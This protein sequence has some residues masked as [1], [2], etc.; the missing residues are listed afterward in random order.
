MIEGCVTENAPHWNEEIKLIIFHPF[1]RLIACRLF[2]PV[3]HVNLIP[4][5]GGGEIHHHKSYIVMCG[6]KGYGFSTVLV[7]V[8]K[9]SISADLGIL[10][11]NRVWFLYS[12]LDMGMFSRRSLSFTS[13][14]KRKFTEALHKLCLW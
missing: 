5:G 10:V 11:I 13:L 1:V 6:P 3:A 7:R 12:N 9:V 2:L 4:G 14:P 8:N